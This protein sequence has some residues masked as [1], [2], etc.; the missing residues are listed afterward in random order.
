MFQNSNPMVHS[1]LPISDLK[2]DTLNFE[3]FVKKVANG[4]ESY[5]QK[6]CFIISIEGSWE[7]VK[8]HLLN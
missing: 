5:D 7:V 8:L 4:I 3:P 1:D 6:D 2:D